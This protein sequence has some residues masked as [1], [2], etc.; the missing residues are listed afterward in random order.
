MNGSILINVGTT[1]VSASAQL[2]QLGTV[3]ARNGPLEK[4]DEFDMFAQSRN[5]TYENTKKAYVLSVRC[6][7]K[8]YVTELFLVVVH[9]RTT[10]NRTKYQGASVR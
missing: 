2:A 7:R 10:W 9:T 1:G 3:S 6:N 4:E 8:C 5:A